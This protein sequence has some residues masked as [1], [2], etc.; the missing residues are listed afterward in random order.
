MK[1]NFL[2]FGDEFPEPHMEKHELKLINFPASFSLNE[3]ELD[4]YLQGDKINRKQPV[5]LE[6][7]DEAVWIGESEN[8]HDGKIFAHVYAIRREIKEKVNENRKVLILKRK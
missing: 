3:W 5:T 1:N 7:F 8:D 2:K 6:F 4:G